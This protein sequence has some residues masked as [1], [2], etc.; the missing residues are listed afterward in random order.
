MISFLLPGYRETG[1]WGD[2]WVTGPLSYQSGDQEVESPQHHL[3]EFFEGGHA[4]MM[5]SEGQ[6]ARAPKVWSD[7]PV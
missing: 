6:D 1:S 3:Q 7:T 5:G 4:R 2:L